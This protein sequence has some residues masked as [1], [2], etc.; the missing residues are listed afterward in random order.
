LLRALTLILLLS[1]IA[2]TA[3]A[4]MITI[5]APDIQKFGFADAVAAM[6]PLPDNN[7]DS[8]PGSPSVALIQPAM[9]E[10]QSTAGGTSVASSGASSSSAH[11]LATDFELRQAP[12]GEFLTTSDWV[13]IPPRFLHGIFRPPRQG[14]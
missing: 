3:C 10:T 7:P 1:G 13:F 11:I 12:P 9:A 2:Q 4:G 8:D 5:G 6:S 14:S